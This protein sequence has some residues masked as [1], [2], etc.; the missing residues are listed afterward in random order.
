MQWSVILEFKPS[1]P[2]L[3]LRPML[4]ALILGLL[5]TVVIH[6]RWN[7]I[8]LLF[9]PGLF[10]VV[11]LSSIRPDS[12]LYVIKISEQDV[13]GPTAKNERF[14]IPVNKIDLARSHQ[15]RQRD[16]FFN[17]RWLY[18]VDGTAIIVRCDAYPDQAFDQMLAS[19]GT[20]Q[21][22]VESQSRSG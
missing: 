9:Y 12:K 13:S 6:P 19:I 18:S 15:R 4:V 8:D 11:M 16:S 2:K 17:L 5:V 7:V 21:Q 10:I 1:L 3:F 22:K 20:L 14:A